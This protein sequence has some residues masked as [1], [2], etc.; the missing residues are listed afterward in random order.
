LA[1]SPLCSFATL[2]NEWSH[3]AF[4]SVR[5]HCEVVVEDQPVN[6][7]AVTNMLPLFG[8]G[9][10]LEDLIKQHPRVQT[11]L[12]KSKSR[13]TTL[14]FSSLP[15]D[16]KLQSNCLRLEALVHLAVAYCDG[17]KVP[18]AAGLSA[19]F[20]DLGTGY[21]G[22]MEDPA[23]DVF[24]SIAMTPVDNY[25]VLGGI[26]ES[27]TFYLQRLLNIVEGWPDEGPFAL[28][29]KQVHSLLRVSEAVCDRASLDKYSV[30]ANTPARTVS[31]RHIGASR[32]YAFAQRCRK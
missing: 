20:N 8:G 28:M 21:C 2:F 4:F 24:V 9:V 16:K 29:R 22:H 3:Q 1:S 13:E 11:I 17:K 12:S 15:L 26:W 25:R 31:K 23:E 10:I 32:H 7:L 30:G 27:G 18:T 6:V 19:C 14:A 5:Q